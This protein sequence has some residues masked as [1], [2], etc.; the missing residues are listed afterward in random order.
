MGTNSAWKP[1]LSKQAQWFC[2]CAGAPGIG[3]GHTSLVEV[4]LGPWAG[5]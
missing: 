5:G 4:C 1:M 2:M 3:L